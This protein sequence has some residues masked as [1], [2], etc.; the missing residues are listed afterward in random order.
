MRFAARSLSETR[1]AESE[2]QELE[3]ESLFQMV[4][5]MKLTEKVRF[6]L[7]CGKE[8]RTLLIRDGSRA[9]QLAIISNPRI[10]D[11]EIA[12]IASSKTIDEEVL[13]RIAE[14]REWVKY[15]PVRLALAGNPKTP[16]SIAI[17]MLP[18]LMPQDLS[19]IAKSK[20]VSAHDRPGR[21]PVDFAEGM[22]GVKE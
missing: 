13:R 7:R 2:E 6:A 10:T 20:D 15:Y 21:P 9:V 3:T 4:R 14:N 11:G 12:I 18:T 8:G 22:K 19:Q 5:R 17:K 1:I 16:I